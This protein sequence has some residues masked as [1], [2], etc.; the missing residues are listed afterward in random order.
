MWKYTEIISSNDDIKIHT[1][2]CSNKDSCINEI[3][4]ECICRIRVYNTEFN[5]KNLNLSTLREHISNL[6]ILII[7]YENKTSLFIVHEQDDLYIDRTQVKIL[8]D[9]ILD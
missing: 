8:T 3:I 5:N 2:P 7:D 9:F 4:I 1:Y 6:K